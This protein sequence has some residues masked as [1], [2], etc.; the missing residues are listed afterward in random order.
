MPIS[1]QTAADI[2]LQHH[3]L[4][5]AQRV[6][7][8]LKANSYR[9]ELDPDEFVG[10]L[11]SAIDKQDADVG[12]RPIDR[13]VLSLLYD[14]TGPLLDA[15]ISAINARLEHLNKTA[16]LELSPDGDAESGSLPSG[17]IEAARKMILD[18]QTSDMHHPDHVLVHREAFEAMQAALGL[19]KVTVVDHLRSPGVDSADEGEGS[20]Q[21]AASDFGIRRMTKEEFEEALDQHMSPTGG[22]EVRQ[23]RG[24]PQMADNTKIPAS[25]LIVTRGDG[26]A[27]PDQPAAIEAFK[28][29]CR[30]ASELERQ[31]EA[32]SMAEVD[33]GDTQ[34]AFMR[35]ILHSIEA[36]RR[37]QIAAGYDW[38]HDD[39]HENGEILTAPWGAIARIEAANRQCMRG[40]ISPCKTKLIEATAL[41]VAEIQR[42]ARIEAAAGRQAER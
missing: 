7:D 3:R 17:V 34:P 11:N 28:A 1:S 24:G 5:Q 22:G 25:D 29:Q 16:A 9:D 15:H 31:A 30:D 33:E 32:K 23:D 13:I 6:L 36:E 40:W 19:E 39:S 18:Y 37:R 27:L 2:G 42:I 14:L 26:V 4:R 12:N 21:A 20:I 8:R 35:S 38:R 41:I 10:V